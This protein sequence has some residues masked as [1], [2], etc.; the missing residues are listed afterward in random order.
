MRISRSPITTLSAA[1]I[2]AVLV[3]FFDPVLSRP[4]ATVTA[5]TLAAVVVLLM[6]P[7][8]HT[9][10]LVVLS[11]GVS[12]FAVRHVWQPA[13]GLMAGEVTTRIVGEVIMWSLCALFSA[14]AAH[15]LIWYGE[16]I[17]GRIAF[18][19]AISV[20]FVGHGMMS[21]A[22]GRR[23]FPY[24]LMAVGVLAMINIANEIA[25][26]RRRLA[27]SNRDDLHDRLQ[28]S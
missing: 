12:V 1:L 19:C 21:L 18:Q 3:S 16:E 27:Q 4:D 22:E 20:Y 2:I 13:A 5:V 23:N 24:L 15:R 10:M 9:V 8:T 25:V 28:P 7:Q 17:I 26:Y 6:I 14:V 11:A